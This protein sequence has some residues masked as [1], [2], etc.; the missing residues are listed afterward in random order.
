[1][2]KGKPKILKEFEKIAAEAYAEGKS[3]LMAL[4]IYAPDSPIADI[5]GWV[6]F[7]VRLVGDDRER[8]KAYAATLSE[9][10][11]RERYL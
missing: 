2:A 5:D 3:P 10:E 7:S 11:F 9:D 8:E 1:M 4:R 6:D